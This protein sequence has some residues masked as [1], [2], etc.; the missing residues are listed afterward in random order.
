M[1]NAAHPSAR[2]RSSGFFTRSA[3][4]LRDLTLKRANVRAG[5]KSDQGEPAESSATA[6]MLGKRKLFLSTGGSPVGHF[7]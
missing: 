1:D 5:I 2:G 3:E 4:P 7:P 6:V